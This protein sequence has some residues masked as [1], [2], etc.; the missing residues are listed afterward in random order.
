MAPLT[1][2]DRRTL[3]FERQGLVAPLSLSIEEAVQQLVG[4]HGQDPD[5]PHLSLW[6]RLASFAPAGL[7]ALLASRRLVRA[8]LWRGTLHVATAPDLL[9]YRSAVQPLLDRAL[10]GSFGKALAGVSMEEVERAG[11]VLL[12]RGPLTA[13]ELGERLQSHWPSTAP[14]PLA[15][16]IRHRVP[17]VHVPPAG[18]FGQRAPPRM[19][20]V[21]DWLGREPE[22]EPALGPLV[23]RLLAAHGPSTVA[24][25]QSFTGLTRLAA[26][27]KG[28]GPALVA[29]SGARGEALFDLAA[30]P[31][32]PRGR[33]RRV[34]LLGDFDVGLLA[35]DPPLHLATAEERK[36]AF[37]VN[38]LLRPTLRVDGRLRGLWRVEAGRV[39]LEVWEPLSRS[40]LP[41]VEGEVARLEKW[42]LHGS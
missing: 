20:L 10:K 37:T 21:S 9:A 24:D 34:H 18:H 17:V 2:I 28:L 29:R 3:H 14:G 26:V 35:F 39:A 13:A 38:G 8:P 12:S 27:V 19:A 32:R 40:E 6:N 42:L 7:E 23:L 4:L 15:Q 31:E 11:R 25:L 16:V 33:G 1:D 5:G 36:A 41:V 22:G 30:P